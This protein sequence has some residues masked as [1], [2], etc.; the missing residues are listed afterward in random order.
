MVEE[1]EPCMEEALRSCALSAGLTLPIRGKGEGLFSRLLE[2]DPALVR[3]GLAGFFGLAPRSREPV[4]TDELPAVPPRP[5]GLCA[6][7]PHR[8]TYVAVRAVLGDTAIY[9]TDIGCYTLGLLPH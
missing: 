1:G 8:S 5:P 9:P 2:F 6:G 3:R 7:C 4:R